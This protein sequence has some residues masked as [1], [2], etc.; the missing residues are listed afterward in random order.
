[1]IDRKS[2]YAQ[3]DMCLFTAPIEMPRMIHV[4]DEYFSCTS[5]FGPG[6]HSILSS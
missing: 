6:Q 1:M 2:A 4:L 3:L 5:L